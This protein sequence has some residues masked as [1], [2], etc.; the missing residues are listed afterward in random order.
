MQLNRMILPS[1]KIKY[2]KLCIVSPLY[3]II[4]N[5]IYL[6]SFFLLAF[7][8]LSSSKI[9]NS[10][11]LNNILSNTFEEEYFKANVQTETDFFNYL[12]RTMHKL[13]NY[14]PSRTI[15]VMIPFGAV[16]IKKYSNKPSLCSENIDITQLCSDSECTIKML[17]DI[18]SNGSKCGYP[19][20]KKVHDKDSDSD[21]PESGYLKLVR[22]FEGKYSTYDLV[23]QGQ[24]LD[25]TIDEFSSDT[26]AVM[27]YIHDLDAKFLAIEI[28]VYFPT[29]KAYGL[30]LVGVEMANY[31]TFP[32]PI[33]ASTIYK[34]FKV[35]NAYFLISYII[36]C[37][38]VA[39]NFIKLLYEINVKFSFVAHTFNFI[40]EVINLLLII[41]VS[42]YFSESEI[43]DF[44]TDE[45]D[46]HDYHEP[47]V[48]I[49]LRSYTV[50]IT[51]IIFLCIPFR[52]VSLIS[53]FPKVSSPIT[54]YL[55]IL[56]RIL[57]GILI[58]GV[59]TC[60]MVFMFTLMN[61]FVYNSLFIEMENVFNALISVFNFNM[62]SYMNTS[63]ILLYDIAYSDFFIL[64]NVLQE[65]I[66]LFIFTAMIASVIYSVRIA[67]K[68]E[69]VQEEDEVLIKLS[70]IESQLIIQK[71][72]IDTNFD[73]MKKQ[74]VW[75]S[76]TEKHELYNYYSNK[77]RIILFTQAK[78]VDSFFKYLFAI[79]PEMQFKNLKPKFGIIIESKVEK[80]SIP[81]NELSQ[82]TN[83]LDW[84]KLVGAKIPVALYTNEHLD[85]N[86]RMKL[87]NCFLY[88]KFISEQKEITPFINLG[89]E[90]ENESKEKDEKISINSTTK[91]KITKEND[92]MIYACTIINRNNTIKNTNSENNNIIA[93][94]NNDNVKFAGSS[95]S[96]IKS[97]HNMNVQG[98]NQGGGFNGNLFK[99]L[100][101]NVSSN[102]KNENNNSQL[103]QKANKLK[104]L[105][106]QGSLLPQIDQSISE[107]HSKINEDSENS[108]LA[109]HK[110]N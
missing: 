9:L 45:S 28:H 109:S 51:A 5:V 2:I 40:N 31:F 16:R 64:Y 41:F 95:T 53:W 20:R 67:A 101:S 60:L 34:Q 76:L 57:P 46:S 97:T 87:S 25:I 11:Q 58:L 107:E 82:I 63:K 79:K 35:H 96:S 4:F 70:Q 99:K 83:L 8:I 10:Y 22:K 13:Y 74:I 106:K 3:E 44:F 52:F 103:S 54:K 104:S 15:P 17:R 69:S 48:M 86:L 50:I 78:Q 110:S 7:R 47:F 98:E 72:N 73:E 61:F 108:S 80:G 66:V 84:L 36:F 27:N 24:N 43:S 18:Y 56:F 29:Y 26:N 32:Y 49:S 81:D 55:G 68:Y 93:N 21:A 102:S 33:F 42:F 30:V 39:F 14:D 71:E 94:T 91:Y 75:L 37:I 85:R 23:S 105:E 90:E 1:Q 88:I 100:M 77:N 38:C 62:I 12:E 89:V 65:I 6:I 19:S 59:I 92:F